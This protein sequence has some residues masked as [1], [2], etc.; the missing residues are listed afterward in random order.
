MS[1]WDQIEKWLSGI[2]NFYK[3]TFITEKIVQYAAIILCIVIGAVVSDYFLPIPYVIRE[4]FVAF[5]LGTLLVLIVYIWFGIKRLNIEQ[6]VKLSGKRKEELKDDVINAY[7]LGIDRAGAPIYSEALKEKYFDYVYDRIRS[8]KKDDIVTKEKI[9]KQ[10]KNFL[11]V[12]S[13]FILMLLLPQPDLMH[14][15]TR[16]ILP[17]YS[18]EIGQFIKIR[19]N[20]SVIPWGGNIS[21]T[22]DILRR[23]SSEIHLLAKKQKGK[24][25]DLKPIIN[26]PDMI[27]FQL[28]NITESWQYKGRIEDL[29][30]KVFTVDPVSL[31]QATRQRF[32]YFYP[33]YTRAKQ[34]VK[35]NE[36]E[37][38][39]LKGTNVKLEFWFNKPIEKA[40][41][42]F[43]SGY[44]QKLKMI[45]KDHFSSEI[46]LNKTD[47]FS[48]EIVDV[49]GLTNP[50]P[51]KIDVRVEE[52]QFPTI[53]LLAPDT[54]IITGLDTDVPVT[55]SASDDFGIHSVE[56]RFRHSGKID[57]SKE[58][59]RRY[60]SYPREK[61]DD[62]VWRISK[63]PFS[64]GDV[65]EYYLEVFDNDVVSGPKSA[66]S[67]TA[68]LEIKSFKKE[69][70]MIEEDLKIWRDKLLNVLGNQIE[71]KD[72]LE[73][74]ADMEELDKALLNKI[75]ELQMEVNHDLK[76]SKDMLDK[77]V[78]R[79]EED[80][81]GSYQILEEH[82]RMSGSLNTLKQTQGENAVKNLND[83]KYDDA[84]NNQKSIISE[85]EK[86]SLLSE[87]LFQYQNMKD[88][89]EDAQT[90]DQNTEEL[91][92][93]LEGLADLED[94]EKLAQLQELFS[95]I[96]ELMSEIQKMLKDLPQELPEE[97]VNQEAVKNIN[98]DEVM[99]S[100]QDLNSALARGGYKQSH[101]IR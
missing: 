44:K 85:L 7:S 52:D 5:I 59:I 82:K 6:I 58:I 73:K 15:F 60:S 96:S 45:E 35:E 70:E 50:D 66:R 31:P 3:L 68:I 48:L 47:S 38:I 55:F 25:L 43:S 36:L 12:G 53:T 34:E 8:I 51:P 75:V 97:F 42:S 91:L 83:N 77:I 63:S 76:R 74:L 10:I 1:S 14:S 62:Y 26:K 37:I 98:M 81:L 72:S 9:F 69:H 89:M 95:K 29:Y 23:P 21:I 101:R 86:M 40:G 94:Q 71:A 28:T 11:A 78:D 4:W 2:L 18:S 67:R 32:H 33:Q 92:S 46:I 27:V 22:V 17:R 100:M 24:W 16:L 13:I 30:T 79:M 39:G 65:V 90:I 84:L 57:L 54:D 61:V 56:L 41:L 99:K 64:P 19:A 20:D 87:D 93:M 80:P 88:L 49:Q